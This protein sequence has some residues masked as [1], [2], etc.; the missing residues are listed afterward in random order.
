LQW[1]RS[2]HTIAAFGGVRK[3]LEERALSEPKAL[4]AAFFKTTELELPEDATA[5]ANGNGMDF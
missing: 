5:A 1:K 3:A 2:H 4:I